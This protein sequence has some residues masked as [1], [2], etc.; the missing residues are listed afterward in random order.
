MRNAN[1]RED[2][3]SPTTDGMAGKVCP[4]LQN[5]SGPTRR[6]WRHLE[7]CVVLTSSTVDGPSGISLTLDKLSL[8]VH[9]TPLYVC[10]LVLG[11]V[12]GIDV[13]D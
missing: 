8:T 6:A 2:A 1:A 7:A 3:F 12:C 11:Y 9:M 10:V 13:W 5:F 4:L